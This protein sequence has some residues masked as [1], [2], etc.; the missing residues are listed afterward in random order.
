[1]RENLLLY[2]PKDEVA[3]IN[4]E[5]INNQPNTLCIFV[6]LTCRR[7]VDP[8]TK[9]TIEEIECI[10]MNM[11]MILFSPQFFRKPEH[12]VII[13]RIA[14][15]WNRWFVIISNAFA[16]REIATLYIKSLSGPITTIFACI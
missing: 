7:F 15:T 8:N 1:M 6:P 11:V 9:A 10:N 14:I 3:E 13:K 4:M 5:I 12:Q 2:I 16:I